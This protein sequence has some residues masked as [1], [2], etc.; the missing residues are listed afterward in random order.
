MLLGAKVL[1]P[2]RVIWNVVVG[3]RC[4]V[5][6]LVKANVDGV[7]GRVADFG[8]R[9]VE[10]ER[11]VGVGVDA[12]FELFEAQ[13]HEEAALGA[14]LRLDGLLDAREQAAK[15]VEGHLGTPGFRGLVAE[16]VPTLRREN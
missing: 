15:G 5:D 11:A 14:F 4:G 7:E 2:G 1:P 16:R 6:G 10:D 9:D 8:R 12:L 3:E 13:R